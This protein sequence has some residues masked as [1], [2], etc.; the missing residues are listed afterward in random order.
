VNSAYFIA[1]DYASLVPC[2]LSSVLDVANG[3]NKNHRIPQAQSHLIT[4]QM[5]GKSKAVSALRDS[6][7]P[8][9]A[10]VDI[11][12]DSPAVNED[13][14]SK[15]PSRKKKTGKDTTKASAVTKKTAKAPAKAT[16]VTVSEDGKSVSM[17]KGHWKLKVNSV[18][19][20]RRDKAERD[21]TIVT[22]KEDLKQT[23]TA[24]TLVTENKNRLVTQN[25]VLRMEVVE[26]QNQIKAN[27]DKNGGKSTKDERSTDITKEISTFVKETLFRTI[28]FAQPGKEMTTATL[29]VWNGIK[30]RLNLEEPPKSLDFGEFY[31]IY[32]PVVQTELSLAR[33]YVQSRSQGAA[34]CK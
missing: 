19:V 31:R 1:E 3:A 18:I 13:G 8:K 6:T 33:Q 16:A 25:K 12:S 5:Q 28:K 34:Y 29:R 9:R 4:A 32:F 22:H 7:A 14:T 21:A 23:Q 11:P 30:E 10:R 2:C 20:L 24:L 26:L 17:S 15:A 27:R